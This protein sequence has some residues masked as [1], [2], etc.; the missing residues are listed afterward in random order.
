MPLF[1]SA[2]RHCSRRGPAAGAAGTHSW[3]AQSRWAPSAAKSQAITVTGASLSL[4]SGDHVP[5]LNTAAATGKQDPPG[6]SVAPVTPWLSY[7]PLDSGNFSRPHHSPGSLGRKIQP[8]PP[9]P[10]L[11]GEHQRRALGPSRLCLHGWPQPQPTPSQ[12]TSFQAG[13]WGDSGPPRV[14]AP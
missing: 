10:E 12:S 14:E 3:W 9:T 11:R 6:I 8:L 5:T 2:Q 13:L 4:G 1:R 7:Q